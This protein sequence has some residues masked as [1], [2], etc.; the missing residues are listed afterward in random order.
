[1]SN[2]RREQLAFEEAPKLRAPL[3][4]ARADTSITARLSP[5]RQRGLGIALSFMPPSLMGTFAPLLSAYI[6]DTVGLY[7]I[8]LIAAVVY[9]IGLAVFQFGVKID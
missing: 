9:F 8:F 1:M 6:A 2:G 7:P 5:R 3:H 4:S